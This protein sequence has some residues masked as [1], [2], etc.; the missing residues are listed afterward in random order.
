[1]EFSRMGTGREKETQK[2]QTNKKNASNR[3]NN[4]NSDHLL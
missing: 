1:M 4:R 2:E 3:L